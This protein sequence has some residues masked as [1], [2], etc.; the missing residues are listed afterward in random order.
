VLEKILGYGEERIS[1]IVIRRSL[2]ITR[3]VRP[4]AKPPELQA[5]RG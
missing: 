4:E 5:F 3:R 1:E 2:R